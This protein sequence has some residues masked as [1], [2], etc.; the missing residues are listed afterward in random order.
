M[1]WLTARRLGQSARNDVKRYAS[2]ALRVQQE[3]AREQQR[4]KDRTTVANVHDDLER[5]DYSFRE[6]SYADNEGDADEEAGQLDAS[7]AERVAAALAG[8][9]QWMKRL[10]GLKKTIDTRMSGGGQENS[11]SRTP[12]RLNMDELHAFIRMQAQLIGEIDDE[13][14]RLRDSLSARPTRRELLASGIP[15]FCLAEQQG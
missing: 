6:Y 8:S 2:F 4:A 10:T 3:L 13:N 5:V 9:N 12:G 15:S 14:D 7:R 1:N 11:Q